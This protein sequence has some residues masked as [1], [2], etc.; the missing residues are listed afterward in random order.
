MPLTPLASL[1]APQAVP[2]NQDIP[3]NELDIFFRD[4]NNFIPPGKTWETMTKEEKEKVRA[5][6]RFDYM[7][8][9]QYQGI[10]G[11][12]KMIN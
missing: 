9:G 7:R 2:N 6:Y 5:Q 11:L 10:T 1:D 3:K 12:G 8:P 4:I